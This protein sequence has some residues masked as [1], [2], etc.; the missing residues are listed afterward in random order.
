MVRDK[1]I[2]EVLKLLPKN[3]KY[4]FC[5]A[6]IPRAMNAATLADQARQHKLQGIVED[7]VNKAIHLARREARPN[8]FIFI[9]GSTF[10]VAE[11]E[12]L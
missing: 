2:S 3:A 10:V 6:K 1:D 7:D 4:Y 8:D 9:G 12:N 11:I 5:A